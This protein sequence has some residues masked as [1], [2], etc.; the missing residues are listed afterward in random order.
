MINAIVGR[1]YMQD[2]FIHPYASLDEEL[3]A[4]VR[5]DKALSMHQLSA[6]DVHDESYANLVTQASKRR[7]SLVQYCSVRNSWRLYALKPDSLWRATAHSELME[8]VLHGAFAW[9][10][11]NEAFSSYLLGYSDVQIAEWIAHLKW[12]SLGWTGG[13]T[14][15]CLLTDEQARE[16][17]SCGW[18]CC[19]SRVISEGIVSILALGDT[20]L[21]KD[22]YA[23]IPN[24]WVLARMAIQPTLIAEYFDEALEEKYLLS[25]IH[26]DAAHFNG[27]LRSRIEHLSPDGWS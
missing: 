7:L 15:H 17:A 2:A 9:S 20:V 22:A 25:K 24:G 5:G 8:R 14:I 23:H 1:L 13:R 21:R 6:L 26:C 10:Y 27:A 19:P 18:R 12:R 3:D 11:G 16:I 4:V